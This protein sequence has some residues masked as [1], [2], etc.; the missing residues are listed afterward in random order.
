VEYELDQS[1][2]IGNARNRQTDAL[3]RDTALRRSCSS[4]RCN[5]RRAAQ[6]SSPG[7][8]EGGSSGRRRGSRR[9]SELEPSRRSRRAVP[10]ARPVR[11]NSCQIRRV[12]RGQGPAGRPGRWTSLRGDTFGAAQHEG[13]Q[14]GKPLAVRT[15]RMLGPCAVRIVRAQPRA[16][17]ALLRRSRSGSRAIRRDWLHALAND[18]PPIWCPRSRQ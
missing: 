7:E 5:V 17:Q 12:A 3:G 1:R 15:V 18:L 16:R 11:E 9:G 4:A 14:R 13:L 6:A 2:I 8:A 10:I